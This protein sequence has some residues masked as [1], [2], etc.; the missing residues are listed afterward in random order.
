[1]HSLFSFIF[2]TGSKVCGEECLKLSE[3]VKDNAAKTLQHLRH[4][5]NSGNNRDYADNKSKTKSQ[6]PKAV[7][8]NIKKIQKTTD[9]HPLPPW[10][11]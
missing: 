10:P 5:G 6:L 9:E 2:R 11:R 8:E 1:M 7:L 3:S 4:M